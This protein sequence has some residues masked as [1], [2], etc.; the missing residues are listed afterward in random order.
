MIMNLVENGDNCPIGCW[1]ENFV[2]Q[3]E[4]GELILFSSGEYLIFSD[5]GQ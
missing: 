5:E 4:N 3:W 2:P 1:M